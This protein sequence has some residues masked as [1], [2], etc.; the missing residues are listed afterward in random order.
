M[1]S[2]AAASPVLEVLHAAKPQDERTG[3]WVRVARFEQ[4][5]PGAEED[6]LAYAR[7]NARYRRG[8]ARVAIRRKLA[9]KD[10]EAAALWMEYLVAGNVQVAMDTVTVTKPLIERFALAPHGHPQQY[11]IGLKELWEVPAGTMSAGS[12]CQIVR[13]RRRTARLRANP[14][15]HRAAGC[16]RPPQTRCRWPCL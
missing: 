6:L 3:F 10:D 14:S 12:V 1:R 5:T 9:G 4:D 8:L 13:H 2:P 16:P 11:A 15:P 7:G